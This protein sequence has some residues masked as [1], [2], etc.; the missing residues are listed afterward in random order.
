MM[1]AFIRRRQD[2]KVEVR[3]GDTWSLNNV[4]RDVYYEE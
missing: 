4:K 1:S 3:D 2:S